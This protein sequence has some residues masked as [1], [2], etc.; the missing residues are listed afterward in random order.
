MKPNSG[1][2]DSWSLVK[3]SWSRFTPSTSDI[4]W[5][6]ST[7]CFRRPEQ[8]SLRDLSDNVMYMKATSSP[9][10]V[11]PAHIIK[12]IF[13]TAGPCLPSIMNFCLASSSITA[14]FLA[15]YHSALAPKTQPQCGISKKCFILSQKYLLS[16]KS[17]EKLCYQRRYNSIIQKFDGTF[18]I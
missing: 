6:F 18:P 4:F 17:K 8:A 12:D 10:D 1:F 13:D 9:Y 3:C 2:N 16:Q 15:C 7:S 14:N 5:L 11:I